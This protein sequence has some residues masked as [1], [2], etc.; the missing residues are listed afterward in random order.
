[1]RLTF[2]IFSFLFLKIN[3]AINFLASKAMN[4]HGQISFV[5]DSELYLVLIEKETAKILISNR[6]IEMWT[7]Y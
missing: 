4:Y 6:E 1:M 2:P 3:N 7:E 5:N